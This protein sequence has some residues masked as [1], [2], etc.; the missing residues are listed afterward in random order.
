MRSCVMDIFQKYEEE[1]PQ[2][3]LQVSEWTSSE[4]CSALTCSLINFSKGR[5]QNVRQANFVLLV[6]TVVMIIAIIV[7]I[8]MTVGNT[9]PLLPPAAT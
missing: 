7:I 5:I 6:I 2:A 3:S 8:S 4:E 1:N 9:T